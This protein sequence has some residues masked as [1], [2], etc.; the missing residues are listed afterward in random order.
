MK[1]HVTKPLIVLIAAVLGM[2]A[3]VPGIVNKSAGVALAFLIL[4]TLTGY[5]C[6][7]FDQNWSSHMMRLKIVAK[8]SQ[9]AILLGSAAGAAVLMGN[10]A[11]VVAAWWAIIAI[12][13]HSNIE[14][15]IKWQ[16]FGVDLGPAA[17][18]LQKLSG[19]FN[20][21]QIQTRTTVG[22]DRVITFAPGTDTSE[23][24]PTQPTKES[25]P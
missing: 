8:S 12:E 22:P 25:K 20:S 18:L 21:G 2:I 24:Q 14:N 15:L 1:M 23:S 13:A 19:F 3:H 5:I 17:P 9:Y 10:W 6:A 11:F 4:D 16:S 7:G